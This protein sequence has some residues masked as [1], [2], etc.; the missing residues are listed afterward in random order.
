MTHPRTTHP[1]PLRV[2]RSYGTHVATTDG[3]GI[4][5]GAAATGGRAALVLDPPAD[6][7]A[8][9][10]SHR[11][12]LIRRNDDEAAAGT[13]NDLD[14]MLNRFHQLRLCSAAPHRLQ[15]AASLLHAVTVL[16]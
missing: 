6:G 12:G 9:K 16:L 7:A 10:M 14:I 4:A 2:N 1:L 5:A 3:V 15:H 11:T 8:R 13:Y